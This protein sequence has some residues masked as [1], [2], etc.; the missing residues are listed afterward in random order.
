VPSYEASFRTFAIRTILDAE[1]SGDAPRDA[2]LILEAIR[3]G[4]VF[5][6]IDAVAGPAWVD[7]RATMGNESASMGQALLFAEDGSMTFRS[8]LPDGG[9]IVLLRDGVEAGQSGSRELLF[10]PKEPGAY[11]VEVM[12]PRS[13]GSPPVPW[14]VTNPIYLRGSPR[15]L[16][17]PAPT[18]S[19]TLGLKEPGRIERDSESTAT[20]TADGGVDY[21]LR[22]G[23]RASQYAGLVIPFPAAVPPFDAVT[24]NARSSAPMRVSVQIRSD[25]LGGARWGHSVYLSPEVRR[26]VV[27]VERL[28]SLDAVSRTFTPGSASSLLF[29]VD[30]TNARPGGEGRFEISDVGLASAKR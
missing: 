13:P 29:V 1:L 18:Y 7:Y 14:I 22:A 6:A 4:R 5:T 9:R 3:A 28:V 19:V 30:L 12:A 16:E 21:R 2:R 27:P 20:L 11:R 26:I 10:S 23:Q 25:A 15:A 24:F 8:T 17:P